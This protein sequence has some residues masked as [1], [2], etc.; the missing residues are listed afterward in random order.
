VTAISCFLSVIS[1][2][3]ITLENYI[4]LPQA[5]LVHNR[6]G[7]TGVFEYM[8]AEVRVHLEDI[9]RRGMLGWSTVRC[10]LRRSVA[11]F[12]V[13]FWHGEDLEGWSGSSEMRQSYTRGCCAY[14]A[15][16]RSLPWYVLVGSMAVT[17]DDSFCSKLATDEVDVQVSSL[18]VDGLFCGASL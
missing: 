9:I 1:V 14:G 5:S 3:I 12:K 18:E 10:S 16:I 7:D 8:L 6:F 4:T 15:L 13:G 2:A 17:T 11:F